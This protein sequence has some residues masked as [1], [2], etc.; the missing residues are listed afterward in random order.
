MTVNVNVNVIDFE[1]PA[2]RRTL[3]RRESRVEAM[4]NASPTQSRS[5]S[6]SRRLSAAAGPT[7]KKLNVEDDKVKGTPTKDKD[8]KRNFYYYENDKEAFEAR[9]LQVGRG[10]LFPS[11]GQEG[12]DSG[13]GWLKRMRISLRSICIHCWILLR[14]SCGLLLDS[15]RVLAG[16]RIAASKMQCGSAPKSIS[17][18]Y[19]ETTCDNQLRGGGC[20]CARTCQLFATSC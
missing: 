4:E 9:K 10:R 8:H 13:C 17:C 15:P 18:D 19:L 6:R 7:P 14:L 11:R 20:D 16:S 1:M 5:R 2:P 12:E 3:C